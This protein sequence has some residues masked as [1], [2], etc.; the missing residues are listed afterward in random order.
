M[1]FIID[2]NIL[3]SALIRDSFTR[4]IIVESDL[5]FYYPEMSFH[6]VRKYKGLVLKKS[7]ISEDEY[8]R[9]LAKLLENITLL[10]DERVYEN[11]DE[12]KR[13]MLGIDPDDVVFVA[14]KLSIHDS[15]I[16]SD[17]KGYDKQNEVKVIKTKDLI[18]FLTSQSKE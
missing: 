13:I 4:K 3:L 10:P 2:T 17:D 8:S 12:A 7:G 15:V 14:A 18:R 16:W 9:L 5:D 11:L 6:E 1:N